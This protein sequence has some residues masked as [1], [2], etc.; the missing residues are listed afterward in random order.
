MYT[1]YDR[2]AI[3]LRIERIQG[4]LVDLERTRHESAEN[5]AT[6]EQLKGELRAAHGALMPQRPDGY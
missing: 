2:E 5:R 1:P 4:L 3:L 6:F